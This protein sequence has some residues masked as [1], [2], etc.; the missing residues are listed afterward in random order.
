MSANEY[1]NLQLVGRHVP[2][3]NSGPFSN[4]QE[5]QAA[6]HDTLNPVTGVYQFGA[7][8]DGAFV[9]LLTVKASEVFDAVQLGKQ[10]ASQQ[11][12]TQQGQAQ[13]DTQDDQGSQQ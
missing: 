12:A 4:A 2:D 13:Q 5:A 9:P 10:Q 1:A 6:G 8:I 3:A 7:M 11:G